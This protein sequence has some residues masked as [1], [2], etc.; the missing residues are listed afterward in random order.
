MR[1]T[2]EAVYGAIRL[3]TQAKSDLENNYNYMRSTVTP[4]LQQWKDR[5]VEQFMELLEHFD[6]Y[7]KVTANN[8]DSINE[9][10]RLYLNIMQQYN[11]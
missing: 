7:V 2:E 6:S 5:N 8:L 4:L 10:L 9:S 1:I 11:S 3:T